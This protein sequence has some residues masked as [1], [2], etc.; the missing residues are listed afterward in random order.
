MEELV[1]RT[2]I[3]LNLEAPSRAR[4]WVHDAVSLDPMAEEIVVLLLSELVS[5]SV[6]H[7]GRSSEEPVDILVRQVGPAVHVEVVDPGLGEVIEPQPSSD[8]LGLRI[9]DT[10]SDR[11]GVTHDPTTVWFDLDEASRQT[12]S[13]RDEKGAW[14]ITS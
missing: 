11:W 5:N 6:R 9:L 10:L 3:S 13:R 14:G 12:I 7:S 1:R 2:R 8:H 4:R